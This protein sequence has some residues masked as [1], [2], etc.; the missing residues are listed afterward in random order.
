MHMCAHVHG[1][2]QRLGNGRL[3]VTT[4]EPEV[5]RVPKHMCGHVPHSCLDTS[6]NMCMNLCTGIYMDMRWHLSI[7]MCPN[8][9]D[10][11]PEIYTRVDMPMNMC[12]DR[13]MDMFTD[14]CIRMF[15]DMAMNV[16]H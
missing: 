13:C 1:H 8:I 2:V 16:V 6:L 9:P 11:L 3:Y 7:G 15:A 12:I 10:G 5:W 14:M 4:G